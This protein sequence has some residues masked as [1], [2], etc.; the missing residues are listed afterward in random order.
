MTSRG[1]GNLVG[2]CIDV[3]HKIKKFLGKFLSVFASGVDEDTN[4]T[5]FQL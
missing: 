2:R 3:F 1:I 4:C 5:I